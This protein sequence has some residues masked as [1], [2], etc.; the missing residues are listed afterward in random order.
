MSLVGYQ[1]FKPPESF[2]AV[3]VAASVVEKEKCVEVPR[4]Q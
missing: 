4:E 1:V 2:F 3:K